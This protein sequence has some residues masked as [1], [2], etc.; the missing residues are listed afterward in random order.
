MEILIVYAKAGAGHKRAA[1]AIFEA[2]RRKK[3]VSVAIIDC[4]DY[5][6]PVF[7][8]L[9]PLVYIWM[10]RFLP[11]LW[12]FFYYA[13]DKRWVYRLI[14]PYRRFNNYMFSRG[15]VRFIKEEKPRVIISTQFFA[16]EIIADLKRTGQ[17]DSKLISV[18]TDFG[19]HT[20]W[21]SEDVDIFV[22]GSDDTKE[23]MI[24]RKI[25]EDKVMVLGIPIEPP[26]Q[27]FNIALAY[28]NLGLREDAFVILVAGG[29][30]GVGPISKVVLSLDGLDR[31]VR[32]KLQVLVVCSRNEKL[33]AQM[34][35]LV[36]SLKVDTK[37]YGFV[38]D[39]Y[40]MMEVSDVIISKSGGLTTSESLASGLPMIIISP[41]P[42]QETKNCDFL[43]KNGAAVRIDRPEEIKQVIEELTGSAEKLDRMHHQALILARPTAADYIAALTYR[44]L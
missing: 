7:R 26:P 1:E 23:D 30:F 2:F 41:I 32:D 3:Q 36:Q 43:V 25:P 21:E 44:L 39:L 17:T 34:E 31:K 15:F 5:C 35:E 13:L 9:Y 12:A 6:A 18:V 8:Y 10:V 40:R 11:W 22:V 38:P 4:L 29:G 24:S 14:R 27:R 28:Q 33:K 16:S 19:A 20:F 37:I 42:G